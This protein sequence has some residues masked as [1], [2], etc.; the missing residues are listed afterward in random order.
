MSVTNTPMTAPTRRHRRLL[1]VP[2]AT[3]VAVVTLATSALPAG[4]HDGKAI[5]TVD[6]A[7]PGAGASIDYTI[8]VIW[9][10]DGHPANDASVTVVASAE[11]G[12]QV[13]P[14]AMNPIDDDGRYSASLDV[15][16]PGNWA[17][18]FTVV[19]PPGTLEVP[20]VVAAPSTTTSA[21]S[22]TTT[23]APAPT[24]TVPAQ[25]SN[26]STQTQRP[27]SPSGAL[28]F[29]GAT[30]LIIAGGAYVAMQSRRK[31]RGRSS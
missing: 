1:M 20:Q 26:S 31:R 13:G 25:P 11:D 18:R 15:G 21:P 10:N 23:S 24:E 6:S 16:S 7:E 9:D 30:A 29:F 22:T 2:L 27:S 14:I 28:I 8:R 12:T 5:I 3:L 17:V 19:T 4:A